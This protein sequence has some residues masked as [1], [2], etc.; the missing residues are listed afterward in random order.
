MFN[1]VAA[2]GL[3][4]VFMVCAIFVTWPTPPWRALLVAGGALMLG[5]P[6]L[7]YPFSKSLWL[8]FDL[9]FRADEDTMGTGSG[10]DR[11][12]PPEPTA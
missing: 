2:E 10:E 8:A 7:L 3:F 4:A 11:I 6:F 12:E 5:A 1:L 9:V